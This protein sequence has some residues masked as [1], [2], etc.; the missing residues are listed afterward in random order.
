MA[1][2][3]EKFIET[4]YI[5]V[6]IDN[7]ILHFYCYV[8]VTFPLKLIVKRFAKLDGAADKI[9]NYGAAAN[10]SEFPISFQGL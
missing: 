6:F 7:L 2:L 8:M 9:P 3:K 5:V 1:L 4:I 10:I